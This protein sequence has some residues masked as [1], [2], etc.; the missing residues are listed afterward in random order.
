MKEVFTKQFCTI[1]ICPMY[2]STFLVQI[3]LLLMLVHCIVE[4]LFS[5]CLISINAGIFASIC[6]QNMLPYFA[7]MTFTEEGEEEGRRRC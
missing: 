1:I 4:S 7:S 2:A 3:R 5:M 6:V